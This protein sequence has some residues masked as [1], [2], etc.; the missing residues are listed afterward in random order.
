MAPR[1]VL[2]SP[3]SSAASAI[4][5]RRARS[6][7]LLRAVSPARL[8][9]AAP[10]RAIA[11]SFARRRPRLLLL[12]R[13]G[14]SPPPAPRASPPEDEDRFPRLP[15]EEDDAAA[16]DDDAPPPGMS[17]EAADLLNLLVLTGGVKG[18]LA[19][20]LGALVGINSLSAIHPDLPS[21]QHGLLF[22]AP[23]ALADLIV[24]LPRW[25]GAPDEKTTDKNPSSSS[26]SFL[27]KTRRALAKYQRE[28]ALSNP[29]RSMPAWQ[30]ALV[31]AVAR[32][33]EE[34]LE[35]AVVLG[36]IAAWVA[37]RAVEAGAEPYDVE[38]P[39]RWVAV[40]AAAAYLEIRLRRDAARRK[41]AVRAFRVERGPDGKQ[42]MIPMDEEEIEATMMGMKM[43]KKKGGGGGEG[44]GASSSGGS[45]EKETTEKGKGELPN[46]NAGAPKLVMAPGQLDGE[47]PLGALGFTRDAKV[48]FDGA[49]SRLTLLAQSAC[50]ATSAG[51]NLWAPIAGG[52][53]C[54]VL[55]IWYQRVALGRF[56]EEAGIE[57]G[58]ATGKARD[59][60]VEKAQ[61]T[62][63]R[64][65]L[66]RRRKKLAGR[67]MESVETSTAEGAKDFNVAMRAT[68][69][70]VR[71]ARGIEEEDALTEVLD[72]IHRKFPP[73]DLAGMD[74]G[75]SV[76][77]MCEVLS[78]IEA[79]IR[80]EAEE[81]PN[82]IGEGAGGAETRPD[83][84]TATEE[85][86]EASSEGSEEDS[87]SGDK[88]DAGR[89]PS[90]S[91]ASDSP[92]DEAPTSEASEASE[93]SALDAGAIG[94]K[95]VT[96]TDLASLARSTNVPEPR[97]IWDEA[98]EER[99]AEE[100][101]ARERARAEEA[102]EEEARAEA[103]RG[104]NATWD[105]LDALTK[106]VDERLRE[107]EE[108]TGER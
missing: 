66:D 78:E 85:A 49:R 53:A 43:K 20:V 75:E 36:F 83:D 68:V 24:M 74:E 104:K 18:S 89:S 33:T 32:L 105:A 91:S 12:P 39:A 97:S 7:A 16:D 40:A 46:I 64:R 11:P 55:F 35:R 9:G 50:F 4:R 38:A 95:A 86:F 79:D 87:E 30:D 21:T 90:D 84:E 72:R 51:G 81:G 99:E 8:G 94:S 25:G 82:A 2:A 65:D 103:I 92:L 106:S 63:L 57:P 52:L 1:L 107:E 80:G 73:G 14:S 31:A 58:D 100:R 44:G 71:E 45:S 3:A 27:S 19:V 34:M 13:R 69:K 59:A 56:F 98:R 41:S 5:E 47:D 61:V 10:A 96:L 6:R 62:L 67:L 15:G 77:R 54:D 28:E 60:L 23:V 102:A 93:A 26:S 88:R 37:D 17:R 70:A 22:A 108:R 48:L 29:C 42:K 76:A 101:E